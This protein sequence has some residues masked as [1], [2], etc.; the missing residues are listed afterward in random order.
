M[1]SVQ[2]LGRLEQEDLVLESASPVDPRLPK[3]RGRTMRKPLEIPIE[4]S[5]LEATKRLGGCFPN[6]LVN[7]TGPVP[8]AA[9]FTAQERA[10]LI[11][12]KLEPIASSFARNPRVGFR[13]ASVPRAF[14]THHERIGQNLR[15]KAQLGW[16]L[17]KKD[18]PEEWMPHYTGAVVLEDGQKFWARI[19][20][21]KTRNGEKFLSLNL[22]PFQPKSSAP[23]PKC[24]RGRTSA[25]TSTAAQ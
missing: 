1:K 12:A 17:S 3:P 16:V 22:K 15:I 11:A 24:S 23:A 2:T 20:V 10:Q 6:R 8:L 13:T 25:K 18:R 19:W 7:S 9:R 14:N 5:K 21:K 4:R